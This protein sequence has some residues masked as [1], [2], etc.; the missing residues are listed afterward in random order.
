MSLPPSEVWIAFTHE[1]SRFQEVALR[2]FSHQLHRLIEDDDLNWESF[3]LLLPPLPVAEVLSTLPL[4][5]PAVYRAWQ[6]AHTSRLVGKYIE[7]HLRL[8]PTE[9]PH[10]VSRLPD[11]I[12]RTEREVRALAEG[13]RS[14]TMPVPAD[15]ANR[16]DKIARKLGEGRVPAFNIRRLIDDLERK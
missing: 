9:H 16:L 2:F 14:E 1:G 8:N 10:A 11:L 12:Q 6:A 7:E 13:L 3:A 5:V 15:A 4:R